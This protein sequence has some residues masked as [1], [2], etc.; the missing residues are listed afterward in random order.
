MENRGLRS[1]SKVVSK[2]EEMKEKLPMKT[3]ILNP[4]SVEL[5][6][7]SSSF[8]KLEVMV[9]ISIGERVAC[10]GKKEEE[11]EK[12]C[13]WKENVMRFEYAGTEKEMVLK[14]GDCSGTYVE[15]LG[16]AQVDLKKFI[17]GNHGSEWLDLILNRRLMG[18]IMLSYEV[19]EAGEVVPYKKV[20]D[21]VPI[22]AGLADLIG[23]P[24]KSGTKFGPFLKVDSASN[25]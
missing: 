2:D 4:I 9:E 3:L 21:A 15:M 23:T 6:I 18:Q 10:S 1:L 16:A 24:N 22:E 25:G 20:H 13:S 11:K 8:K 7:E 14:I 5:N 19:Y 12:V 17:V